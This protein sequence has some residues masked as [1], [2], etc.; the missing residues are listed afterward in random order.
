[1]STSSDDRKET[2]I[3][4]L[5]QCSQ[6]VS[7]QLHSW[8]AGLMCNVASMHIPGLLWAWGQSMQN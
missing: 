2:D 3:T 1:M 6:S 5:S 8:P 7:L 4:Q